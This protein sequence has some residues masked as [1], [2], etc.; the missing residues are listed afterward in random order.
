MTQADTDDRAGLSLSASLELFAGGVERMIREQRR[1]REVDRMM[2][3]TFRHFADSLIV[4]ASGF[5]VFSFA[6]PDQGH[7]WEVRNI[8]VTGATRGTNVPG[9]V[10]IFASAADLRSSLSGG[11]LSLAAIGTGDQ[12]D[13][14]AGSTFSTQ[15]PNLTAVGV[16]AVLTVPIGQTWTLASITFLYTASA[17]VATR[18]PRVIIRDPGGRIIY[19]W[20]SPVNLTANQVGQVTLSP[21]A[22]NQSG[23]AGT[24]AN[25][26]TITGPLPALTLLPGSTISADAINEDAADTITVGTVI[27]TTSGLP[28][29]RQYSSM[30]LA[31]YA[32]EDLFLII[33]GATVAAELHCMVDIEDTQLGALPMVE[34]V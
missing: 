33:S 6:G 26:F 20:T 30:Q 24:P 3:P 13:F 25:P 4:P 18:T 7:K 2:Q 5:A 15:N 22:P 12:R 29:S 11:A 17:A 8:L 16:P 23:G 32:P 27:F 14:L 31:I 10:D 19:E 34:A 1:A 21:G 9:T 28:A